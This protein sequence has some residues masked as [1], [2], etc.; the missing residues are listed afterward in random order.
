MAEKITR[1]SMDLILDR[2]DDVCGSLETGARRREI[3]KIL[4]DEGIVE[5]I[6][7]QKLRI[8]KKHGTEKGKLDHEEFFDSYG[9]LEKRY[10][11]LFVPEDGG[12]NPTKWCISPTTGE[13]ERMA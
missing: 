13:W 2:I 4:V 3:E 10:Q 9:A 1:E 8:Y 5:I 7:A 6:K 12:L 11:K